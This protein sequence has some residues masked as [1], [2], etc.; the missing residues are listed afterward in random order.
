MNYGNIVETVM[1]KKSHLLVLSFAF[2]AITPAFADQKITFNE[3]IDLAVKNNLEVQASYEAYK[4]SQYD[5]KSTRSSFFP[6]ISASLSYDKSNTETV[7][8][9]TSL[10]NDGY[11]GSLNLAYNLFNGFSD[12]ASL[13]IADSNIMT[14][15]ANLQETKAQ[16]SYDLKSAVA[17][18]TYAKDSLVLSKDILKRREDNLRMVELRFENGRENKGSV[19]LSKAY[20][21]QAKLDFLMAQNAM[22]TSLIFLRRVLNLPEDAAIDITNVPPVAEQT[23][24]AP[25]FSGIIENTPTAKR[26]KATLATASATLE[27]KE[28]GFYPSWDVNGS[29]GKTGQDF[30]PNENKSWK[31]GTSLTWSL[32]NGGKDYYSS[33]SSNLLVKAAEKRLENQNMELK[34]VLQDSYSSFNEAVQ[35]VKVSNAFLE[36]AKVR[37]DISRSKYNNGLTTFD[38][39]DIIENDL[40]T[41]QKD[42]T[43]KIRNRLIAEA[44]W[45]QA[46]GTGVIP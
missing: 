35:A 33:T 27:T 5:K 41:R 34:R 6:R 29:V 21:E 16:I 44:S 4:A 13:K 19:L 7:A 28:S 45:E 14:S 25:N 40:I 38:D 8:T 1:N 32:F 30:F 39:W 36:A 3:A 42:N 9:G 10:T 2:T 43:T 24:T 18:Y 46:Q 22:K 37:A 15:E 20:L 17:N 23:A 11:T 31:V 12:Y 26:F